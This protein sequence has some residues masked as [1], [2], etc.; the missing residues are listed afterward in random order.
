MF[1]QKITFEMGRDFHAV[2]ACEHCNGT[3]DMK[4]GYDDMHFHS[5]VIP[6]MCCKACGKNRDGVVT[7]RQENAHV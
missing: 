4:H 7:G 3:Q 6:A 5:K 1:I 2:M